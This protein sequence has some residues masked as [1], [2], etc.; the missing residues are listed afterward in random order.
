MKKVIFKKIS[1]S[2]NPNFRAADWELFKA[3]KENPGVSLP[4]DYE[5]KG[6]LINFALGFPM[7]IK[8]SERNGIKIEGNFTSSEVVKIERGIQT[9]K[10]VWYVETKNSLYKIIYEK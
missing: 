7:E 10:D 3:G 9:N 4:I 8:R 1:E 6:Q 5:L 2:E